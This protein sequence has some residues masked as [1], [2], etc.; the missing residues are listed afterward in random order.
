MNISSNFKEKMNIFNIFCVFDSKIARC[1]R[2]KAVFSEQMNQNAW[3][4]GK[5]A[6][7]ERR[8]AWTPAFPNQESYGSDLTVS[9]I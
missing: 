6:G 1:Y 5:G 3:P 9:Q 4:F 7:G 8:G 2:P